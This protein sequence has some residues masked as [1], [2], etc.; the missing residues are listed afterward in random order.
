MYF[1]GGGPA[2]EGFY[3]GCPASGH[4]GPCSD[5]CR[6]EYAVSCN[7]GCNGGAAGGACQGAD[8]LAIG[9]PEL[10][11]S[12]G[13]SS[14]SPSP[15][16]P[17]GA[18]EDSSPPFSPNHV[19]AGPSQDALGEDSLFTVSPLFTRTLMIRF[20]VIRSPM[21]GVNSLR[22]QRGQVIGDR[23]AGLSVP[24]LGVR[25]PTFY[26]W[27]PGIWIAASSSSVSGAGG[28]SL[29]GPTS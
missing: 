8:T 21:H 23:T 13:L 18:A 6:Y 14:P 1:R 28:S 20:W 12:F 5:C 26:R 7:S 25:R 27:Q 10:L 2:A 22:G 11:P 3:P 9:V 15:T 19:Q 16:L 17:W 4:R 24:I 29:V